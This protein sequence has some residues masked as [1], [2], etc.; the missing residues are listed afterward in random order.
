MTRRHSVEKIGGVSMAATETVFENVLVAGR[1][2]AD[3]Y[4]RIFVV[5][6]YAGLTVGEGT[7]YAVTKHAVV[8]LS[9]GTQLELER[10]GFKPRISLLES[11]S[12]YENRDFMRG[13]AEDMNCAIVSTVVQPDYYLAEEVL[14]DHLA[15][16]MYGEFPDGATAVTA[17][18]EE[19]EAALA[20]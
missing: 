6:A 12:L 15:R 5:S 3:L 17:A 1:A 18:A 13:F 10:G 8:A 4:N 20:E 7:L 19:A 9:E 2:G 11:E 14:N 16:A